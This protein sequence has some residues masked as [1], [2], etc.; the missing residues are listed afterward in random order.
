MYLG[1]GVS[2]RVFKAS[3]NS[4][5]GPSNKNLNV[6]P[7]EVVLSITSATNKSSSPKYSLFP[8]L[9]F[10]AGSTRTSQSLLSLLSSLNK[11]TSILAPVFSS[12]S[13]LKKILISVKKFFSQRSVKFFSNLTILPFTFKLY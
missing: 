9:I 13:Y 8:I 1:R 5:Y 3:L 2:P 12:V 7:L 10:R 11:N 4:S 6:L